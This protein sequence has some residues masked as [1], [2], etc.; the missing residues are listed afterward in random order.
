M[1]LMLDA[2]IRVNLRKQ[3]NKLRKQSLI[4]VV[5]Y[6]N[7]KETK[8]LQIP[9][10]PLL[11]VYAQAGEST[12]V[13]LKVGDHKPVKVL[14][15]E[16]QR[17]AVSQKILHVDLYEVNMT[18]KIKAEIKL[19]FIGESK[20]VK[21]L[22]GILVKN[23]DSLDIECLPDDLVPEIDVDISTLEVFDSHISVAD[24]KLPKGITVLNKPEDIIVLVT[25]PRSEKELEELEAKVEEKVEEVEVEKKGKL[26]EPGEEGAEGAA[27]QKSEQKKPEQK[28]K[29]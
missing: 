8:H 17:D 10:S 27:E 13:D 20:A 16:L 23:H 11:K 14:I 29:E 2:K 21:A 26:E 19:N 15:H 4:P 3:T 24:L 25:E 6:G 1:T 9:E 5:L 28:K 12:L 18:E 22:G 7:H